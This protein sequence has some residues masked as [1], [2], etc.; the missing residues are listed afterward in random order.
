MRRVDWTLL[1]YL[2]IPVL[3]ML[4][5]ILLASLAGCGDLSDLTTS[6][7]VPGSLGTV[8]IPSLDAKKA[9]TPVDG[10]ARD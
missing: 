5:F 7:E 4:L 8:T 2:S 6:D 9:A 3:A 10:G 1:G